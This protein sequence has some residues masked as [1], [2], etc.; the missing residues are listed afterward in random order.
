MARTQ[1]R[2]TGSLPRAAG[3]PAARPAPIAAVRDPGAAYSLLHSV[4][5][6]I[7]RS[8]SEPDSAS[9]LSRRLRLPRQVLNYHIKEMARARLLRAAGRRKRRA[10]FEQFYV[11]SAMAYVLSP[12]ILGSLAADAGL[13]QDRLSAEFLLGLGGQLQRELSY[14][15]ERS[16]KAGKRLATWSLSS[17]LRFTSA[18]Q[19]ADF[20]GTLEAAVLKAVAAHSSPSEAAGERGRPYRLIL[21]CYPISGRGRPSPSEEE[22]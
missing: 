14:A 6:K 15:V 20:V 16:Q 10:L 22:R 9:G 8:L 17:E 13:P 7:L 2:L 4:R 18:G 19:R 11:A 3:S 12:E 21:G 5:R 1:V